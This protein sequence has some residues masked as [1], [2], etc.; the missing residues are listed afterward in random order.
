MPSH[1]D[2]ADLRA[3]STDLAVPLRVVRSVLT[4]DGGGALAQMTA[5]S[6]APS[7]RTQPAERG[8]GDCHGEAEQE[9]RAGSTVGDGARAAGGVARGL[10]GRSPLPAA[11]AGTGASRG[12]GRSGRCSTR[13]GDRRPARSGDAAR[14]RGAAGAGDRAVG[15]GGTTACP[16]RPADPADAAAAAARCRR[17]AV[18]AAAVPR[19]ASGAAAAAARAAARSAG[20]SRTTAPASAPAPAPARAGGA[21]AA[22]VEEDALSEIVK[23]PVPDGAR[24]ALTG[25]E[26]PDVRDAVLVEV[27]VVHASVGDETVLIAVRDVDDLDVLLHGRDARYGLT[28]RTRVRRGREGSDVVEEIGV[29]EPEV[30]GL[31]AAHRETGDRPRIGVGSDGIARLNPGDQILE[32]HVPEVREAREVIAAAHLAVWN[33]D[34]HRLGHLLRQEIIQ[35]VVGVAFVAAHPEPRD[36][37]AADPVQQVDDGILLAGRI[38]RRAIDRHLLHPV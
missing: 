18:P 5:A 13:A 19:A 16:R 14:A 25:L 1:S 34:D 23:A 32:K 35:D 24:V 28:R 33:D 2:T 3:N 10:S 12:A 4:D 30:E 36:L 11:D 26:L 21:G 38:V 7:P 22:R 15:S 9:R 37:V 31:P 8:A 27:V 29:R 17:A 6:A 20:A